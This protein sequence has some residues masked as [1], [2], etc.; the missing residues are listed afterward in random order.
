M[1]TLL[2][3]RILPMVR[4]MRGMKTETTKARYALLLIQNKSVLSKSDSSVS[5]WLVGVN[6]LEPLGISGEMEDNKSKFR[7]ANSTIVHVK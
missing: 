7:S 4:T 5:G 1:A 2:F 3:A 6:F